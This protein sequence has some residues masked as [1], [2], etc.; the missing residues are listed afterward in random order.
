M[1]SDRS[2]KENENRLKIS[3][4]SAKEQLARVQGNV[5]RRAFLEVPCGVG[6]E[7]EN[8]SRAKSELVKPLCHGQVTHED[9]ISVDTNIGEFE[10]GTIEILVSPHHVTICGM[11]QSP[12]T[13]E[14]TEKEAS[15]RKNR[16]VFRT[17]ELPVE[18]EPSEVTAKLNG[19]MLEIRFP[20]AHVHAGAA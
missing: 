18:V 14:M 16:I 10:E 17:L 3:V 13:G 4:V 8:W 20:K 12:G 11:P 19:P 2:S 1:N 7:M 9:D 15:Q 5:A 6:H